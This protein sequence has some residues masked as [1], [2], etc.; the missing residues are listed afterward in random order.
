LRDRDAEAEQL[1]DDP[2]VASARVLPREPDDELLDLVPN[3]R[4]T[5]PN[6]RIRPAPRHQPL[7]PTSSVRGLT[8]NTD[9]DRRGD[10]RLN[11][12]SSTRSD[13]R[14]W[15]C[16][17]CRRRIESSCL[18]TTIS[19]SFEADDRNNSTTNANRRQATRYTNDHNTH[20][21]QQTGNR[22]YPC[23]PQ[24]DRDG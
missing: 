17:D 2:L 18:K 9:Q 23:P 19:S 11:A 3:R 20:D 24:P 6:A 7:V 5:D 16:F 10:T 21:L 15:G 14:S 12:A 8:K 13:F 4:P 22:P 1:T